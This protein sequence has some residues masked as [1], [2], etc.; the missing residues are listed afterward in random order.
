M[1]TKSTAGAVLFVGYALAPG[2]F[3]THLSEALAAIYRSV[4]TGLER[5]TSLAAAACANSSEHLARSLCAALASCTAVLASLGL[6][7]KALFS[8]ELLLAGSE[9]ELIAAVLTYQC[10]VFVHSF[11]PHF[12]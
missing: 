8:V 7:L 10:L 1:I 11:L 6:M 12:E 4:L 5:Y 3:L 9:N 2:L